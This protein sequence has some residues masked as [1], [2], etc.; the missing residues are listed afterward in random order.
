M[1]FGGRRFDSLRELMAK[2]TPIRSGDVLAGIAAES[3]EE[4]VAAQM[5]LADTPLTQFLSEP[6]IPYESDEVTRLIFDSHNADAFAPVSHMT[7]GEFREWL[8]AL[9]WQFFESQGHFDI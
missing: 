3:A 9:L 2:A 7:V 5:Q 1:T 8:L 6:L 4:Q